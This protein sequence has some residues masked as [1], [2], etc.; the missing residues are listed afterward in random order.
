MPLQMEQGNGPPCGDVSCA[1][2]PRTSLTCWAAGDA[3]CGSTAG[4]AAATTRSNLPTASLSR[5]LHEYSPGSLASALTYRES[6][7][8]S[9][10]VG[11]ERHNAV[12]KLGQVGKCGSQLRLQPLRSGAQLH[13]LSRVRPWSAAWPARVAWSPSGTCSDQRVP[14]CPSIVRAIRFA[15]SWLSTGVTCHWRGF[16]KRSCPL[17]QLLDV[18]EDAFWYSVSLLMQRYMRLLDLSMQ[19]DH[20]SAASVEYSVQ[21]GH[22]ADCVICAPVTLRQ[23][24]LPETAE[25]VID[26]NRWQRSASHWR[27]PV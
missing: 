19:G 21:F 23:H 3:I 5:A 16:S 12:P 22:D 9:P 6:L 1:L 26:C 10:H 18:S 20:V 11:M 14:C 24:L 27:V 4:P 8:A 17:Q 25:L 7:H 15:T 2:D 13:L